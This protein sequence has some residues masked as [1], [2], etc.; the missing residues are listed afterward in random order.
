M[1]A[2]GILATAVTANLAGARVG[3][4]L[5]LALAGGVAAVLV[6]ASVAA[7]PHVSASRLHPL[8]PHGLHGV[9]SAIVV[10]FFAFAG[11]EAVAHLVGEFRNPAR[12]VKRATWATLVI[13]TLLYLAVAT[14]VVATG[15][16]GS[17]TI[18]HLAIGT[19]LQD[20]FGVSAR[21]AAAVAAL[22][23]S[24]GTT[25]AFV[26]AVSRL[27]YALARD[28][29]L[30]APLGAVNRHNVPVGGVGAVGAVGA[31]GLVLAWLCGWG[32]QQIVFVPSTLVIAVYLSGTAAAVKLLR[33][34]ARGIAVAG[35]LL[36]ACALPFALA[37]LLVPVIVTALALGCRLLCRTSSAGPSPR[38][39]SQERQPTS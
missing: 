15:T 30:P 22:V 38:P 1:Y 18:D 6:L 20:G 39:R 25:N 23:I 33:G 31:A 24:L 10:L 19:L 12:D 4:T 36:T 28:R 13:V 11:W 14:A 21:V 7:V 26:A 2:A 8:A 16:Y 34:R 17:T 37:H 35:M 5:Q 9:G 3:R 27:C 29:W 32:T